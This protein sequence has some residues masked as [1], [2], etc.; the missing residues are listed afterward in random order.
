MAGR[1]GTNESVMWG[2]VADDDTHT[3]T[4]PDDNT[5]DV[6]FHV[7]EGI[8]AKAQSA[9]QSRYKLAEKMGGGKQ[10][11]GNVMG[12]AEFF[13]DNGAYR[14]SILQQMIKGWSFVDKQGKDIPINPAN[15]SRLPVHTREVVMEKI[16]GFNPVSTEEEDEDLDSPSE[17][18]SLATGDSSQEGL[19]QLG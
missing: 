5:I 16:D 2:P 10:A 9:A 3:I 17:A 11:K 18:S 8:E 12:G 13:F 19:E 6:L 4:L 1:N 14:L 15:I 7:T